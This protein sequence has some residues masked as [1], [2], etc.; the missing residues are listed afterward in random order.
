MRLSDSAASA[1]GKSGAQPFANFFDGTPSS[2]GH[3]NGADSKS[4]DQNG[5]PAATS[6]VSALG[7]PAPSIITTASASSS[8]VK[9]DVV[10]TGSNGHAHSNGGSGGAKQPLL[11]MGDVTSDATGTGAGSVRRERRESPFSLQFIEL[12]RKRAICAMRDLKGRF[13]EIVLP[14]CVVALVL[15]I[16]KL[17]IN[18]A[19]PS[20][21]LN[22]SLY[23]FPSTLSGDVRSG[24][25]VAP[26][27]YTHASF[28][29]NEPGVISYL[30]TR[31]SLVMQ[32][33]NYTDSMEM[34]YELLAT[35]NTH[36]GNR[37]SALV[38]ND[39][40]I[41]PLTVTLDGF[42]VHQQLVTHPRL[43]IMQNSSF[44]H[45]LP[46]MTAEVVAG[47]YQTL[48]KQ[49]PGATPA[50][51]YYFVRNHPLPLTQAETVRDQTFLSF[52]ASVFVLIP[53]T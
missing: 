47:R 52:F 25:T 35:A 13:F 51:S 42:T 34:S 18:P 43:T 36:Q 5:R 38:M 4:P 3:S 15:L 30:Q 1:D 41:W 24:V 53:C 39:T 46:V 50:N 8:D 45:T 16:L 31:P 22:S 32:P 21:E 19:G 48:R 44:Y 23:D 27:M 33:T 12:F 7:S 2:N 17:N 26:T 6:L 20:I 28:M 29:H 14:V 11:A 37:Y 9:L 40:L 49:I 10:A